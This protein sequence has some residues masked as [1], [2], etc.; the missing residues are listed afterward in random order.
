MKPSRLVTLPDMQ[1][2]KLAACVAAAL[3]LLWAN[4]ARA[5]SDSDADILIVFP[6]KLA[7]SKVWLVTEGEMA[8]GLF[9]PFGNIANSITLTK[10]S[11]EFG[12][13]LDATLDGFDRYAV[14]Y[15]ALQ[16]RF[17]QRS[18][19]FVTTESRAFPTYVTRKGVTSAAGKEGYDFV[20]E[21]QEVFSGLSMLNTYAT[22]TDD[23]APLA[24][25][26][27]VVYDA[28]KRV[29]I[30]RIQIVANGLEK[31]P[32]K[33]A[34]N[35]KALFVQAYERIAGQLADQL[36]GTLFSRDK[37]HAMAASVGRGDDVPQV[38]AVIKRYA[39]H[40]HYRFKVPP[41][42]RSM[43]MDSGLGH[44]L[45]PKSELR[46]SLGMRFEIELLIPELGQD[47][48]TLDE[49]LTIWQTRLAEKGADMST[50]TEFNDIKV[51]E[52]YRKF[53][54]DTPGVGRQIF[55]FRQ[56][57]EDMLEIVTIVVAKD[58]D[59]VYPKNRGSIQRMISDAK[60][61]LY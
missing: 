57:R 39:K 46:Y 35:D 50:L 7:P 34:V 40:F 8:R 41:E 51:S 58:F 13:Q 17:K 43:R 16:R 53:A 21:I 6:E 37:L 15:A 27:Y 38:K 2:P 10:R 24:H 4:A 56:V 52:D 11:E 45:V 12:A 49:Y 33:E 19:A 23:V 20:I 9:V 32:L 47:V 55:L 31:R 48:D 3:L 18:S 28:R 61:A 14:L 26:S 36:I 29:E 60:L 22:K 54:A 25:L 1:L 44:V 59:T 5:V 42:W 30:D